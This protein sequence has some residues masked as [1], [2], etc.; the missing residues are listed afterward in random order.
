MTDRKAALGIY[1]VFSARLTATC[2]SRPPP[3]TPSV[4]AGV[5]QP[6]MVS[7]LVSACVW[8]VD[9][10]FVVAM[11]ITHTKTLFFAA[12][13]A[14]RATFV[15]NTPLSGPCELSTQLYDGSCAVVFTSGRTEATRSCKSSL[16]NSAFLYFRLCLFL[17]VVFSHGFELLSSVLSFQSIEFP[18]VFRTG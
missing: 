12:F 6:H 7:L 11:G 8:P 10:F 17:S 14:V 18:V 4:L 9:V 1:R 2:C 15:T 13:P 16:R 3:L 5:L